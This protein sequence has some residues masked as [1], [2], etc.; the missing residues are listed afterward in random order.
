M[1]ILFLASWPS[2]FIKK[3]ARAVSV[4]HKIY[5]LC[6][7][8][9]SDCKCIKVNHE[10]LVNIENY[11]ICMPK[12][13]SLLLYAISYIRALFK[14]FAIVLNFEKI[15]IVHLNVVHHHHPIFLI[16]LYLK[17]IKN[18]PFIITE[19]W[20]GYTRRLG[21]Y[22]KSNFIVKY[23]AKWIYASSSFVTTVSNMLKESLLY[24]KLADLKKITVIPNIIYTKDKKVENKSKTKVQY[25]V[26][27]T[28]KEEH[29]NISSVIKCFAEL[30]KKHTNI[31]LK[32]V[33]DGKDR[34]I[35]TSMARNIGL[36]N[37]SVF[38][39]GRVDPSNIHAYYNESDVFI[40]NSNYETFSI[41]VAEAIG[42]GVPVIVSKCG[43][44]EE[45]FN[46]RCG[47]MIEVKNDQQLF[48]A[49]EC[50]YHTHGSYDS[51]YMYSY[52]QKQ[53]SEE[54]VCKLLLNIYS[55]VL[56]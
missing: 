35:L 55:K 38:F 39:V 41:V 11:W 4:K 3:Y 48:K 34:D 28:L 23:I 21:K 32:I 26:V 51:K 36:L 18:I 42:H 1:N 14:A 33:G 22:N 31:R 5:Y 8:S 37:D 54:A 40:H 16:A 15:D 17:K 9:K 30:Y 25:L 53:F 46:E 19:H 50:M 44:P 29:K 47:M 27:S 49:M 45:F 7:F 10:C 20:T 24:Y 2:S 12:T 13:R 6:I 52:I 56:R 43:G